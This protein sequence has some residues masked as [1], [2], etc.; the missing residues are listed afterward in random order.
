MECRFAADEFFGDVC[1]WLDERPGSNGRVHT[2][3]V[4]RNRLSPA[5]VKL[6]RMI[7][8][9]SETIQK[10]GERVDYVSAAERLQV[11]AGSLETWL[12][13]KLPGSA[14]WIERTA[15]RRGFPRV[16]LSAAPVDVGPEL[17]DHLFTDGPTVVMTSATLSIGKQAS[18]E[19]LRN[20]LGLTTG[21]DKRLGSP[22]DYAKQAKLILIDGMPDPGDKQAYEA[23][24]VAMV[25][26]YVERTDGRAFVLFT[27]YDMLRRVA[28]RLTPWLTERRLQ[29]ITQSDG[30]PRGRM[31]ELFK[32]NP[33][34]VLFGTDS[35]W[36]GVD[37][38]GDALQNVII[39]KLPFAVPDQPLIEARLEAIQARGGKPF[40]E[41]SLPE[42]VLKLKQGFGRLIRSKTDTGMVV[43]LDPRIRTKSYG[44][45]FLE[46]LPDCERVIE[47]YEETKSEKRETRKSF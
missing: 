39:T 38:P 9:H 47:K 23:A 41:Y 35:F 13:Q 22:F 14:Y 18:F 42:A 45:T 1:Q 17:R 7:A 19:H 30:T 37:V 34:S 6:A 24:T 20:R 15:S 3:D 5:L 36:Q 21:D 44:K 26:R 12:G 40:P 27:A 32:E 29:L 8:Q 2:T 28:E 43:I 10:D 31:L 25:R 16:S 11:L 33:R 4:V 46:S